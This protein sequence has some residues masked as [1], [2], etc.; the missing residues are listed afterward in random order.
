MNR[1]F[2]TANVKM[3]GGIIVVV[4]TFTAVFVLIRFWAG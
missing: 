3:V 4:A 2:G 1:Q